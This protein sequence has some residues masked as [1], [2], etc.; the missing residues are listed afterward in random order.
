MSQRARVLLILAVAM[1]PLLVLAIALLWREA[2]A[3]EARIARERLGLARAAA[4]ATEAFVEGNLSVLESLASDLSPSDGADIEALP[5][6]LAGVVA[7]NP[8]WQG[9]TVVGADGWN[10]ASSATPANTVNTGDRP[11]FQDAL[12]TGESV[13]SAAIIGRLSG[14]PSIVFATPLDLPGGERGALTAHVPVAELAEG[15]RINLATQDARIVLVDQDGQT[16]VHPDEERVRLLTPAI[17]RPDVDAV[18]RGDAGTIVH[19]RDGVETLTAYAPVGNAGWGVLVLEPASTAFAPV[20]R[21]LLQGLGLLAL[22]ALGV[23]L[24]G[25]YFSGR[26][27]RSYDRLNATTREADEARADAEVARH[28]YMDLVD[29]VDAIVW[30]ADAR[31]FE[32][33]YVSQRAERILGYPTRRWLSEPTFW[34]DHIHADDREQAVNYCRA[35]TLAGQDHSFEYRAIAADGG[36]VWLEDVVRVVLDPDGQPS[37]LRGVM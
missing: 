34:A 14:L 4:L 15:L 33:H 2:G 32:F 22:G 7:A 37:L 21:A 19:D 8:E 26:L 27:S 29:G 31:T 1:T 36:V 18:L 5:E 35:C 9:F 25:W 24:I 10:L 23:G 11:Y 6:R 13:V 28:K 3:G 30:E 16:F 20:Q 12:A 17:G